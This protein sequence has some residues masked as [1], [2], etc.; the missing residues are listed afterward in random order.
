MNSCL[1]KYIVIVLSFTFC[2]SALFAGVKIHKLP[3]N[4]FEDKDGKVF[5]LSAL[6]NSEVS[7]SQTPKL[8]LREVNKLV[9]SF[10]FFWGDGS[11]NV[12]ECSL[13]ARMSELFYNEFHLH[14]D[15]RTSIPDKLRC[16][17]VGGQLI[18]HKND[19]QKFFAFLNRTES[20]DTSIELDQALES[21]NRIGLVSSLEM[22]IVL[23]KTFAMQVAKMDEAPELLK[24]FVSNP[25]L[26]LS[27]IAFV[28]H[29]SQMILGRDLSEVY[30]N[31]GALES[32]V[33]RVLALIPF[34]KT[35]EQAVTTSVIVQFFFDIREYL[36]NRSLKYGE[37]AVG[38]PRDRLEFAKMWRKSK[39]EGL[40]GIL[41]ANKS[42]KLRLSTL[43]RSLSSLKQGELDLHQLVQIDQLF[44]EKMRYRI[45]YLLIPKLNPNEIK[46]S[47]LVVFLHTFTDEME[48]SLVFVKLFDLLGPKLV[49][50]G[51]GLGSSSFGFTYEFA[52][53]FFRSRIMSSR[54]TDTELKNFFRFFSD[55]EMGSEFEKSFTLIVVEW[56]RHVFATYSEKEI[57]L[58]LNSKTPIFRENRLVDMDEIGKV[59]AASERVT[60]LNFLIENMGDYS[61]FEL[62]TSV[63]NQM[64]NGV[65]QIK[66]AD[67]VQL[68]N[69]VMQS[70][71]ISEADKLGFIR[72]VLEFSFGSEGL[73]N[74]FLTREL[75]S[76]LDREHFSS[77]L[78][79]IVFELSYLA[80]DSLI[81]KD[82]FKDWFISFFLVGGEV[83]E[84]S[85]L[86]GM[87]FLSKLG[88]MYDFAFDFKTEFSQFFSSP[89]STNLLQNKENSLLD[90]SVAALLDL[91]READG[92][93]DAT[94]RTRQSI[95][96]AYLRAIDSVSRNAINSF[97]AFDAIYPLLHW[98]F[99]RDYGVRYLESIEQ[100]VGK[101]K[102]K[103][104]KDLFYFEGLTKGI[105][106]RNSD[107]LDLFSKLEDA[108]HDDSALNNIAIMMLSDETTIDI[109]FLAEIMPYDVSVRY[110]DHHL[111]FKLGGKFSAVVSSLSDRAK[112]LIAGISAKLFKE[113]REDELNGF[114]FIE[115]A[116]PQAFADEDPDFSL[117]R[118]GFYFTYLSLNYYID[119]SDK[120]RLCDSF[121]A[122]WSTRSAELKYLSLVR[123]DWKITESILANCDVNAQGKFLDNLA[124]LMLNFS[125]KERVSFLTK[126]LN[127]LHDLEQHQDSV[128]YVKYYIDGKA[129][130]AEDI[131]IY[132]DFLKANYNEL[133]LR[134]LFSSF[135]AA[136]RY[137]IQ[138]LDIEDLERFGSMIDLIPEG[139]IW[140]KR[141]LVNMGV[142]DP[143]SLKQFVRK[144]SPLLSAQRKG[145]STYPFQGLINEA[146]K[147][148]EDP[149]LLPY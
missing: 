139:S 98:Q 7:L 65:L 133:E 41:E 9:V 64:E 83:A 108:G 123:E 70:I 114:I 105:S 53:E 145:Y 4:G 79:M 69:L 13:L 112:V 6:A 18:K 141:E 28:E 118:L 97:E 147:I 67:I 121:V 75:Y 142:N 80:D 126:T 8:S 34:I 24:L 58:F 78:M 45:F 103:E 86:V 128:N 95:A 12:D 60:R 90:P 144:I 88:Q 148:S 135:V 136:D 89:A 50:I 102:A 84:Q 113:G 49:E 33:Q 27:F 15:K 87:E 85:K 22:A 94:T 10:K 143:S 5:T 46:T 82:R 107:L 71:K 74:H 32:L 99:K 140:L 56:V 101:E 16:P 47:E 55:K 129:V 91:A 68:I 43:E 11:L 52:L 40:L 73:Q 36:E 122:R 130:V 17:I 125:T 124:N 120:N 127:D 59:F 81:E 48:R 63:F 1:R 134:K 111:R 42:Q 132:R 57:I 76:R 44:P 62:L 19:E 110:L 72:K 51:F 149:T 2:A 93:F 117:K 77:Q 35:N 106:R 23:H 61:S 131:S 138:G 39:F 119:V 92:V 116:Q 54:V 146:I 14:K 66:E 20:A 115:K 25:Y 37:A 30:R 26:G 104:L 38:E 100:D 29:Y 31:V 96:Q 3:G 21:E 109:G 137:D